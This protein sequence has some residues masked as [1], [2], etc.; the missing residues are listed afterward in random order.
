[1]NIFISRPSTIGDAFEAPYAAFQQHLASKGIVMKRLGG[2]NYSRK[3]PLRAVVDLIGDC[4]GAIILGYPQV[5][6]SSQAKRS[7]KVQDSYSYAF[8]TPWNQIEGAI[9]YAS[10]KPILVVAHTGITGGV[11]DHG[12]T[13]EGVLHID[14]SDKA[15]F[16]TPQFTQPYDEWFADM[17]RD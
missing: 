5:E 9:A 10:N 8:P 7:A 12:I 14:L 3:A 1:M 2:E 15:W 11:F 16:A 6:F 13:G 17:K 4:R